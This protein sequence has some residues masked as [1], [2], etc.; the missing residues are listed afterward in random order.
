MR[1]NAVPGI[2]SRSDSYP[3]NSFR[4][5]AIGVRKLDNVEIESS[6]KVERVLFDVASWC[7]SFA[8]AG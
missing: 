6:N 4:K 5:T 2:M 7:I 8:R 1:I 3:D